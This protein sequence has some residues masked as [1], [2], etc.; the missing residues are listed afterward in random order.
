MSPVPQANATSHHWPRAH[1]EPTV[2]AL[3]RQQPEDFI[4]DE[5]LKHVADGQG[6]HLWVRVEKRGANTA[7]VARQLA[8]WAGV[9]P[10]QVS[11]AG[12]KD[13]HALTRQTFSIH[14]PGKSDPHAVEFE[15][16]RILARQRSS[17]KLKRGALT[18]NRFRIRLRECPAQMPELRQRFEQIH[19]LGVPNYFGEQRFG[20]DNLDQARMWL[21]GELRR[22]PTREQQ[23]LY[24]SA[25]RSYLFNQVLA[26]RVEA[27]TWNHIILG[28]PVIL[29]GSN[30]WFIA[31]QG[32]DAAEES[33]ADRCARF[34]IHPSGPLA[35]EKGVEFDGSIAQLERDILGREEALITELERQRVAAHRRALRLSPGA[36]RLEAEEGDAVITMELP[37]GAYATTVLRELVGYRVASTQE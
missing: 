23:S 27:G 33:L 31:G 21:R 4:V 29:A 17:R 36:L 34:D 30:A 3:I 18:S 2:Q 6:E 7:W 20:Y 26:E 24:L 19:R 5:Q 8:R 25:V 9:S 22:R 11:Y 12:L 10:R 32:T 16:F 35:G 28:E 15:E 13:R 37:S 14:L 1:G